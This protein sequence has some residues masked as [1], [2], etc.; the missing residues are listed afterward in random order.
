MK[1]G[2]L[3]QDEQVAQRIRL[4][5]SQA[6]HYFMLDSYLGNTCCNIYIKCY[7]VENVLS[8]ALRIISVPR[9]FV[10]CPLIE[11]KRVHHFC[12][13]YFPGHAE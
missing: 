9:S 10:Q 13:F 7:E 8:Y 11:Y 1:A 12:V 4:L 2:C 5:S 3:C 6:T